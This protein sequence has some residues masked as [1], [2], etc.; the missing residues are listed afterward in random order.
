[1]YR[2]LSAYVRDELREAG[3]GAKAAVAAAVA[4]DRGL[5]TATSP[6]AMAVE[7]PRAL[8]ALSLA[9]KELELLAAYEDAV[10]AW[11]QDH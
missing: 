11:P 5:A 4:G 2:A 7:A 10:A 1:M 8:L 3:L 6:A 9:P